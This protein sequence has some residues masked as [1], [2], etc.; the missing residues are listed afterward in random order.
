MVDRALKVRYS[1]GLTPQ[2]N[3]IDDN[4]EGVNL[5]V[6]HDMCT[7]IHKSSRQGSE[8]LTGNEEWRRQRGMEEYQAGSSDDIDANMVFCDAIDCDCPCCN[9][10]YERTACCC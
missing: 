9:E 3:K 1:A 10:G 6:E 4:R 7:S 2:L 8:M 5:D